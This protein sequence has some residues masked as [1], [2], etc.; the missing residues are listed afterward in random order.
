M[1]VRKERTQ[2]T[3]AIRRINIEAFAGPSEARLVE[4]LRKNDKISLS[5]VALVNDQIVGHI[6]FSP[7]LVISPGSETIK[8]VGLGLT[9]LTDSS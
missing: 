1:I 8:V 5:L 4:S 6:I 2:Y 9:V 3:T 7:I